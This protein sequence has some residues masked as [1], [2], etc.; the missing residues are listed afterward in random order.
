MTLFAHLE[1]EKT[2]SRWME[3]ALFAIAVPW[4]IFFLSML[5]SKLKLQKTYEG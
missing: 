5:T 1:E 4:I 2:A 3:F